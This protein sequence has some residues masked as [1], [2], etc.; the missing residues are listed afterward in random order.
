MLE[1]AIFAA[2][3]GTLV[4]SL[5]YAPSG[6]AAPA[7]SSGAAQLD[8][9]FTGPL[10]ADGSPVSTS[11]EFHAYLSTHGCSPMKGKGRPSD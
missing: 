8:P 5:F 10:N 9:D 6:T 3:A 7:T 2:V 11:K 4:H 1:L